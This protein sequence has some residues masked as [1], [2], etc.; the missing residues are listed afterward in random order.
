MW[1]GRKLVNGVGGWLQFEFNCHRSEVFSEK[2]LSVPIGQI[3]SSAYGTHAYAE[4]K[5]PLLAAMSK[6]AGRRP[7][8]DFVVCDTYPKIK[9]AI[10]TKWVGQD[11]LR[12]DSVI[13]DLLRLE[14]LCHHFKTEAWFVLGGKKKHIDAF[15]STKSFR[16]KLKNGRTRPL[17]KPPGGRGLALRLHQPPPCRIPT[18]KRLFKSRELGEMEIPWR[19]AVRSAGC[20]PEECKASEYQV[21]AWEIRSVLNRHTFKPSNHAFYK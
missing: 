20:F 13:W 4:F 8:I 15:M 6:A 2:Y 21:Y 3:L 16:G 11:G 1:L 12:L 7:E 18:L 17:L 14:M 10:E 19:I 5:H 9:V